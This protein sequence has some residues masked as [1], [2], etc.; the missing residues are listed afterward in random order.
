MEKKKQVI[1]DKIPPQAVELEEA[2]IGAIINNESL[3]SQSLDIIKPECFYKEC[4]QIIYKAFVDMSEA[5]MPIDFLTITNY[6]RSINKIDDIGGPYYITVLN[7]KYSSSLNF[8]F[9]CYVVFE[10]FV[11]RE[12]I[13]LFQE[14]TNNLYKTDSDVVEVYNRVYERLEQIFETLNDQQVK[15]MKSSVDKTL[16][17]IYSYSTGE[18]LSY[19]KT[20]I[21]IIDEYVYLAPKFILGIAAPRGCGKTRYLIH[22]IRNI[23]EN[24]DKD[25]IAAL[26]YS[27]EDSDSKIIRLFAAPSTGLT[28]N[29]MQSKGYKLSENEL[30]R[31]TAA[32]NRFSNYNID[33]VNEQD[34]MNKI[35]RKFN[36]FMRKH[37]NKTC[38]LIID[39]IMLIDDL[40]SS[41]DGNQTSIEDRIAASMRNIVNKA[42]KRGHNA[43]I[44]FL[45]HMTKEM[46]SRANSEEAYRPKLN[47]MKG[48][49]RF[50]D[51]CNAVILLNNP[52]M[53]KDL[54][55]RHL[56]LPDIKCLNSDGTT[57]LVKRSVLLQNLLISEV[58][59][60]RD[61][62]MSDDNKAVHRDV[63][64]FGLMKFNEL[65]TIK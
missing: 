33:F 50:A 42:D 44:I 47:H 65:K 62:E 52:G 16:S 45:H 12:M 23:F 54:I 49:T 3:L 11:R 34:S 59:K 26:W 43:I 48:T 25:D 13:S 18:K 55:K 24:N 21:R 61:G 22:L 5:E 35:T 19:I 39:N 37:N 14:E 1:Y 40:Y 38:F 8:E 36:Q 63:V 64:D 28:D 15:H 29:Q 60:N 27:M 46:E 2:I 56:S 30:G 6:L 10:M 20:G 58:A 51:I 9:Y 32:I 41:K 57:K 17:E 4:N 7:T 53:H 31:V